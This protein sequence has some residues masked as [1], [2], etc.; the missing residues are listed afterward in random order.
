MPVFLKIAPDL[1]E[2]ELE[3]LVAVALEAEIAGIVATNTTLA[4]DGLRSRHARRGGRPVR[5]AALRALDGGARAGAR[6]DR[7]PLP[8]IGVG[9][10]G[11][12]EAGLCQDPRRRLGRAA[13]HRRWSTTGSGWSPRILAGLDALLA[14]DGFASVAEAVGTG[15]GRGT[16]P[17]LA[18]LASVKR[19]RSLTF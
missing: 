16:G 8:L 1:T 6:A 11:S 2:A 5:R 4:R 18:A 14:R 13:L 15:A 3:A 9:G 12:A 10:V 17:A 19:S 7:R